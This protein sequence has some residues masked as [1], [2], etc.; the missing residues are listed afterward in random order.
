MTKKELDFFEYFCKEYCVTKKNNSIAL[1]E[2]E[3]HFNKWNNLNLDIFSKD[4]F[5]N[6]KILVYTLYGE[7]I[8][9]KNPAATPDQPNINNN[10]DQR[11][12]I[13]RLKE[14]EQYEDKEGKI[15]F[16]KYRFLKGASTQPFYPPALVDKFKKKEKIKTLILTEGFKKAW[17]A[18]LHGLDVVGLGS[19]THI[20]DADTLQMYKGV[21]DLI[22]T[23][24]VENVIILWDG[25]CLDI[26]LA[27]LENKH[28]LY[29]RPSGFYNQ[30]LRIKEL[31]KDHKVE[32]Y[33]SHV[34]STSCELFIKDKS[35][36]NPKGLDDIFIAMKGREGELTDD[37]LAF[38][39]P[40]FYFYKTNISYSSTELIKHFHFGAPNDFYYFHS[41]KIEEFFKTHPTHDQ[42]WNY[43]GT[44]F[45]YNSKTHECE[46]RIPKEA[47]DYF[48]VGDSYYKFVRVPNKYG[49]LEVSYQR[50]LK[51][52]IVDDHGKKFLTWVSCYEAFC[53][54]PDNINFN[55]TPY[56]CF[57]VYNQFEHKPDDGECPYIL[58]LIKHIF[59][60]QYEMGLDYIQLLYQHPTEALPIIG[61]V[62]EENQTGKS[63]FI[64]LIK[65]IFTGNC[66][67][68]GNAQFNDQFNGNWATKLIIACEESIIEKQGAVEMLK[69]LS[70]GN[71]ISLRLMQRDPVEIDFFGKFILASNKEENF[72]IANQYDNRYWVIKIKKPKERI[73][74]L[75]KKMIEEIPAFLTLLNKRALSTKRESRMWFHEDLYLGTDAFKK[76]I[77]ANRSK[78]EKDIHFNI[79]ELFILT[80]RKEL[81]LPFDHIWEKLLNRKFE[82]PYLERTLK[83][84]NIKRHLTNDGVP[85]PCSCQVPKIDTSGNLDYDYIKCRPY[86]FE[87]EKFITAEEADDYPLEKEEIPILPMF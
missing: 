45:Q 56:S 38:S 69:T 62:S 53:N 42:Q 9:V 65:S 76:L 50:R 32:I 84:M 41:E 16:R 21:L 33:F 24:D 59:G 85:G 57:N 23:C 19:I 51:Q 44:F 6:L 40:G 14:P 34:I 4:E 35:G 87:R 74:D 31:L 47:K 79:R 43:R 60:D 82:K 37:L 3:P 77:N 83:I 11:H 36:I 12:Y 70:T 29:K 25:D 30:A 52:T 54:L 2:F 72:I 63:T 28:D 78:I 49:Q 86:I 71:K 48:R 81:K 73:V 39:R 75:D 64:Q 10:R 55:Q 26:S 20:K 27:D 67:L 13:T 66:A 1:R 58:Q 46:V 22:H 68:I 61:L 7:T 17:Y 18:T 80:G 5:G 8:Q 15:K